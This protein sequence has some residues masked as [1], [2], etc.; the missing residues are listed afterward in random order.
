MEQVNSTIEE[1][2]EILMCGQCKYFG[3]NCKRVDG[4]IIKFYRPW[5]VCET[6]VGRFHYI[7]RDY[8]PADYCVYI[9]NH[10]PGYEKYTQNHEVQHEIERRRNCGL[11]IG[12]DE[13][14]LYHVPSS[15]FVDGTMWDGD[16]LKAYEK[17]YYVRTRSGFGYKLITEPLPNG[18]RVDPD[19]K[20]VTSMDS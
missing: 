13:D 3:K 6:G 19:G 14:T 17:Q 20:V 10:Y 12:D 11:F 2:D 1:F 4:R 9:K 5:F 18:V 8:E 7:C 16:V 15:D